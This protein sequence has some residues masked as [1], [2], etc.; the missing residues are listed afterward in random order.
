M[1]NIYLLIPD[2]FA[3]NTRMVLATVTG[4]QGSTPQKP[5]S[6]ALFSDNG[7]LCGT[8]GGGVVEGRVQ[9]AAIE[10]LSSKKSSH[11]TYDLYND[12][13]NTSEAICGG[14]ISVLLDAN[15]L[16]SI[17]VFSQL[18][19]SLNSRIPGVLISMVTDMDESSVVINRYWMSASMV[20][21]IQKEFLE[22][23]SPVV[24]EQLT[25]GNNS[26]YREIRLSLPD[27][28]PSS[29][30]LL[31]P[32]FP[33]EHL[34]IAG[35]GHIGRALARLGSFLDFEVTVIDN[36]TEY[37]NSE[38]IPD[39]DHII[40]EDIGTAMSG[41]QKTENTYVV[42]VTRGHK[43]DA[44]ALKPCIGSSIAYTGMIG[45]R[46]KVAAMRESFLEKGF[47]TKEAWDRIYA[48]VGIDI[49]S[50]TVEEI[51]ISIAAQL[52]KVRNGRK[53]E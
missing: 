11:L 28:E 18:R 13:S 30:F 3:F 46:K 25:S 6:S 45:S 48:P 22:K 41:L 15:P 7:L 8:I 50:R 19:E 1:K 26:D 47:A 20:P 33:P 12:I 35:A 49:G 5:G 27:E 14:K 39:A 53:K 29:L 31:E 43:D 32:V 9:K 34:V 42:I 17:N 16:N 38:N 21:P 2:E 4:T 40:A 52:I 10:A 36:R 37:A 24:S 51:A 44:D 23:I